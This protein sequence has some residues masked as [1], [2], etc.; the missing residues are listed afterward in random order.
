VRVN[1]SYPSLS[2]NQRNSKLKAQ[3]EIED[4]EINRFRRKKK[5][6][7]LLFVEV[8]GSLM[9]EMDQGGLQWSYGF[10]CMRGRESDWLAHITLRGEE[11]DQ[12][13]L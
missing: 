13:V 10:G 4:R 2:L 9:K 8:G 11:E 6:V 3:T 5:F 7:S 12:G 1:K